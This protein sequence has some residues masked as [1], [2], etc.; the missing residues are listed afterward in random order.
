[1]LAK[2]NG[3]PKDTNE[4]N[5]DSASFGE[6]RAK[7]YISGFQQAVTEICSVFEQEIRVPGLV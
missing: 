4:C 1:M 6:F 2:I 3:F 5:F 7:V